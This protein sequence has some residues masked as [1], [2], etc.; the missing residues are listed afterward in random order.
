MGCGMS[1]GIGQDEQWQQA[2]RKHDRERERVW[3]N[4][5]VTNKVSWSRDKIRISYGLEYIGNDVGGQNWQ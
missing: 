2:R 1:G 3:L 5:E 4:R